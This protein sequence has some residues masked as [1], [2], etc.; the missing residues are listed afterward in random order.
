MTHTIYTQWHR[1]RST[2]TVKHTQGTGWPVTGR[3]NTH[4]RW[5]IDHAHIG[6][7]YKPAAALPRAK[8]VL[9]YV[10]I[11]YD[12]NG[13]PYYST[14]QS[15]RVGTRGAGGAPAPLSFKAGGLSPLKIDLVNHIQYAYS[16][17]L[18]QSRLAMT[19]YTAIKAQWLTIKIAAP[20]SLQ[21]EDQ[22]E[23]LNMNINELWILM[24]YE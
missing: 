13:A 9:T 8:I 19:V 11:I 3:R 15:R 24:N 16:H 21:Q 6:N 2:E 1:D 18:L 12:T 22:H 10:Y 20:R 7:T 5:C 17:S 23:L 4:G 14:E